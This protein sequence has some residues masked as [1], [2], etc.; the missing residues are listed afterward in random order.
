MK[1][2]E[3]AFGTT[4]LEA[5]RAMPAQKICSTRRSKLPQEYLLRRT[6]TAI[7]CRELPVPST[8]PASKAM[9]RCW[10]DG[11]RTKAA[12]KSYFTNDAPTVAN[13][14]ARAQA[15]FGTNAEAFLKLYPAAT[16]A[17]A[18]RSAQDF[19]GDQFIAYSHLEM[20]RNAARRP[21]DRRS[22]GTSSTRRFRCPGTQNGA[23]SRPRRMP[24]KSSSFS[25]CSPRKICRGGRRTTRCRNSWLTTGPTS[26]RRAIRTARACRVAGV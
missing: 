25:E 26:R 19:A 9:S 23:R 1:F 11:T 16:D 15:R 20:A 22:I 13:Y 2:A 7:S 12:I 21:A 24:P 5:L 14:V 10:P 17:Q 6:L 3:S 4:S 8:R 18:K